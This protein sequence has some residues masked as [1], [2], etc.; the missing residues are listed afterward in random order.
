MF[1]EIV[2]AFTHSFSAIYLLLAQQYHFSA[3]K[4]EI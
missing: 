3:H 1:V 4:E 2:V